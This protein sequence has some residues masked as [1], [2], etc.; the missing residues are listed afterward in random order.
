MILNDTMARVFPYSLR[1][2][3]GITLFIS[4]FICHNQALKTILSCRYTS[5]KLLIETYKSLY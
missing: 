2:V 4:L 1:Q 3:E 5:T